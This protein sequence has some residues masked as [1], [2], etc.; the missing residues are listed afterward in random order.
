MEAMSTPLV[1]TERFAVTRWEFHPGAS[2]AM[3]THEHDYVVVPVTG[4]HFEV[5][6]PDGD[7]MEVTQVP[8][9]PYAR[10][11]G[12]RHDVRYVGEGVAVFLE[13]EAMD[14]E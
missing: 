7:V 2:T 11:T 1:R 14:S 12:T 13:I 3:H 10:E 8:A 5:T 4:G 9:E 6:M